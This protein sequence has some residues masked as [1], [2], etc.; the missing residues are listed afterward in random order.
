MDGFLKTTS[1]QILTRFVGVSR[2]LCMEAESRLPEV[3]GS[4]TLPTA[5]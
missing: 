1:L 3:P 5:S 4:P 2:L